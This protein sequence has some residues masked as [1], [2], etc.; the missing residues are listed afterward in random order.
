MGT[1]EFITYGHCIL[2]LTIA[3]IIV[4]ASAV[5]VANPR[6]KPFANATFLVETEKGAVASFTPMNRVAF[7]FRLNP[8]YYTVGRKSIKG[9][10]GRC[11]PFDVSIF[12]FLLGLKAA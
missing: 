2:R 5:G 4:S 3:L 9:G 1:E 7:E 10:I 12:Y 8:G 6:S 11:R